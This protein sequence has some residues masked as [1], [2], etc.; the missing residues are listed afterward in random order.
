MKLI[1]AFLTAFP[2]LAYAGHNGIEPFQEQLP[3]QCGDTDH[4]LEGL[5]EQFSEEMIMMAAAKTANG[6]DLF[7]SLWINVNTTTWTL[8]AVNQQ[9]GV[10]CVIASGD[11]ANMMVPAGI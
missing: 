5:R 10:S 2:M 8:V 4:L 6:D 11:N 9:K 1:L 3:V 7:H